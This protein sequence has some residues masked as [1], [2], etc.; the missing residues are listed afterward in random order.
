[1][2]DLDDVLERFL[3][4]LRLQKDLQYETVRM[5]FTEMELKQI[6]YLLGELK[7]RREL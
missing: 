4:E 6:I 2:S 7:G 1:M 5:T 3:N